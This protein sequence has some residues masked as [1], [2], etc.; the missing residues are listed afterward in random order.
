MVRS[1][2][3]TQQ[4]MLIF[5][6]QDVFNHLNKRD[7]REKQRF[8]DSLANDQNALLTLENIFVQVCNRYKSEYGESNM[9]HYGNR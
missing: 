5:S 3:P 9:W 2:T 8:L 4:E 7:P 1:F 6:I